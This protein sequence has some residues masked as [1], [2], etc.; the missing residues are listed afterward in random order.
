[1]NVKLNLVFNYL[2][3]FY[4]GFIGIILIPVYIN[5]MGKESYGLVGFFITIQSLFV[6]L[7]FGLSSTAIKQVSLYRGGNLSVI[8]YRNIVRSIEQLFLLVALFVA[9]VFYFSSNY[10]ANSWF[11]FSILEEQ[12]VKDS[13][14][15]IGLLASMRWLYSFYRGV[16]NGYEKILFLS[17]FGSLMAT[18]KYVVV[19]LALVYID[20]GP[21]TFFEFQILVSIVELFTIIIV[22]YK[23]L[24]KANVSWCLENF[25]HLSLVAKFATQVGLIGVLWVLISQSD[26]FLLSNW[27]PLDEYGIYMMLVLGA[28]VVTYFNSGMYNVLLPRISVLYTECRFEEVRSI[29]FLYTRI[30]LLVV[31]PIV[32]TIFVFS[33]SVLWLWSHKSY[34]K[35]IYDTFS[36]LVLGNLF[37][38]L[39]AFPYLLQYANS[40]F[41]VALSTNTFVVFITPF[42]L[43]FMFNSY[44]TVGVGVSWLSLMFI[45]VLL[46]TYFVHRKYLNEDKW[47]WLFNLVMPLIILPFVM[48]YFL[49]YMTF[50]HI[51]NYFEIVFVYSFILGTLVFLQKDVRVKLFE[52]IKRGGD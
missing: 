28:S 5:L 18:L 34:E 1:M 14:A 27:L 43:Y 23:L 38:P 15:L 30:I 26:K 29:Y 37:V 4:I 33:D 10:L 19:I 45:S 40:D 46:S 47:Y 39:L 25:K 9:I 2:S 52:L 42:S 11:S 16:V 32:A 36:L 21:E 31:S 22:A 12:Q 49:K 35:D 20:N 24:P 7:D 6:I 51:L 17:W 50:N 48:A 8:N 41:K 44:G 13:L 3:Q